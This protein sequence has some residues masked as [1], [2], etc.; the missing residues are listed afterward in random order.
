MSCTVICLPLMFMSSASLLNRGLKLQR[1]DEDF[2][3]EHLGC[4]SGRSRHDVEIARILRKIVTQ[5]FD[6]KIDRNPITIENRTVDEAVA[7]HVSAH[8]FNHFVN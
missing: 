6:L 8:L 5:S 3:G 2:F 4:A 7:R 1:A